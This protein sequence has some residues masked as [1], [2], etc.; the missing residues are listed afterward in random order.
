M[1]TMSL[2]W[3]EFVARGIAV[4][5][6]ILLLLRIGGRKQVGQLSPF[7]FVLL[8]IISNSVQNSMNGGDNSL[9]GGMLIA[10]SLVACN[11]FLGYF[12]LKNPSFSYFLEGK[13]EVFIH[14]GKLFEEVLTKEN[15]S[16]EELRAILRKNGVLHIEEVHYGVIESTGDISIIKKDKFKNPS[17]H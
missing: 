13:P 1:F 14:N 12:N 10:L 3:W 5:L 16:H 4:Y 11:W 9:I 8:L 17:T 7:D 15:I 6:F 2:P